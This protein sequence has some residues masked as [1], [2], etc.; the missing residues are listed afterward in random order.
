VSYASNLVPDDFNADSDIFIRE[1]VSFSASVSNVLSATSI[2]T[3]AGRNKTSSAS[4]PRS[5]T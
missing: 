1:L 5:L 4:P 2:R 3:I